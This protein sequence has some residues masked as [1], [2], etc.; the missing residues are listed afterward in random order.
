MNNLLSK[1][2]LY[3]ILSMVIPGGTILLFLSLY[4]GYNWKMNDGFVDSLIFYFIVVSL[5]YIIGIVN[6]VVSFEMWKIFRNNPELICKGLELLEDETGK[7][8]STQYIRN[9]IECICIKYIVKVPMIVLFGIAPVLCILKTLQCCCVF[10][11][12]LILLLIMIIVLVSLSNAAKKTN[13]SLL[14]KYYD[15]YYDLEVKGKLGAISTIE[16]QIAFIESMAIPLFLFIL[17]PENSWKAMLSYE[18]SFPCCIYCIKLLILLLCIS[19]IYVVYNRA[20]KVHYLVW[21]NFHYYN[22]IEQNSC[23]Q[24]K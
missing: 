5:A 6:H 21:C 17:L 12:G 4:A 20:I 10:W 22:K 11:I 13:Q 18:M 23:G 14:S 24:I 1:L 3:D 8:I 15:A 7:N 19:F 16:G 2:S 9:T